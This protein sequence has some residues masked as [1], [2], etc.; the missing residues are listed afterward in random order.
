MAEPTT[1]TTRRVA[2]CSKHA[3]APSASFRPRNGMTGDVTLPAQRHQTGLCRAGLASDSPEAGDDP[4]NQTDPSGLV[5][6]GEGE[7]CNGDKAPPPGQ[8]QAEACATAQQQSEQVLAQECLNGGL[9]ACPSTEPGGFDEISVFLEGVA[10]GVLTSGEGTVHTLTLHNVTIN[11]HL[12]APCPSSSDAILFEWQFG[13][14]VGGLEY[15]IFSVGG[16]VKR[17]YGAADDL[18]KSFAYLARHFFGDNGG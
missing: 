17:A 16:K 15:D 1:T 14:K 11:V 2:H 9:D 3:F 12:G 13:N 6:S 18:F 10:N 4:V 8:T 7:V 5:P